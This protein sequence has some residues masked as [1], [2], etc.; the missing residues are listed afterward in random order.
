MSMLCPCGSGRAYADCC[1]PL[2]QGAPAASAE[3]LMR[4]RYAAHALG[5][6]DYLLRSWHPS[7]RPAE[8]ALEAGVK[9]LGLSVRQ[10]LQTDEEHAVVEFIARYREGGGSA[11]RLQERSRFLREDGHW[12]YLDGEY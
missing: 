11:Q 2:H 6:R 8:Y 9:W 5:L 3:A 7:K 12:Y 4:S 10:H 1:Q